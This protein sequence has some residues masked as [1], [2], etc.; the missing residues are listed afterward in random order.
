MRYLTFGSL[1]VQDGLLT[2]SLTPPMKI[3]KP[4]KIL[5]KLAPL[6]FFS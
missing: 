4:K 2:L 3:G 5:K 6:V 1:E